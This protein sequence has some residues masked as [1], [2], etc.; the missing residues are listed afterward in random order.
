MSTIPALL[1]DRYDR[2][3]EAPVL[4][5]RDRDDPSRMG[6][7]DPDHPGWRRFTVRDA[8]EQ[9]SGL[10]RRLE[11]LGVRPGTRVALVA[12]PSH[13]WIA[14]DLAILSLGGVTVGLYVDTPASRLAWH[15]D[16]AEIELL[17]VE[18]A[19]THD[20]LAAHLDDREHLRHV[21]SLWPG[22]ACPPLTPG[23]PDVAWLRSKLQALSEDTVAT[24]VYT[25]GTTGLPK[26]VVLTHGAFLRVVE[27]TRTALPTRPGDRSVLY[28]PLAHSLQRFVV[29]RGLAEDVGGF[30]CGPHD[31]PEVLPQAQPD[32]L[33]VVPRVLEVIRAT[34]HARAQR[35]PVA[36]RVFAWA[37]RVGGAVAHLRRHGRPV[38]PRLALQHAL[39]D[40][41]VLS[42]IRAGLGGRVRFLVSGGAAL[43]PTVQAWFE[44]AGLPTYEGWGLTETCAPATTNTPDHRRP[45]TVG[46]PLPGVRVRLADDGE[47]EVQTPGMFSGYLGDPDATAAVLSAD[48][49]FRTGDLGAVDPDGFLR[50]VGRKKDLLVTA[51]GRNVAPA[52]LEQA[53]VGGV[54]E[55]AV[56]VGSERRKLAAL[57]ALDEAVLADRARR[58]GWPGGASA[59]RRR[60]EIAREVQDRITAA[61]AGRLPFEQ[62]LLHAILPEA[63]SIEAGTLTP[64]LKVRRAAVEA[65]YASLLD[66]LY[67]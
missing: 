47:V 7:L 9:V 26:G 3:P 23:E 16:H 48:G 18:D 24:V 12:R 52:P 14:L 33:V 57:L 50:I 54:V 28:L 59:W 31:L 8:A 40:H 27:A 38:P 36:A 53:L 45:G 43:A 32:L 22:A 15:L 55:Q 41:L 66:A 58:Q 39:A 17:V 63:L 6:A 51:G 11:A 21:R 61:N 64:T 2:A 30:L 25:S 44:A 5:V 13:L 62:V 42:R 49:W 67:A 34:A 19:A 56:V 37:L 65:R 1:L 29:Y 10:A 20:R 35:S 46:L 60:P 4:W